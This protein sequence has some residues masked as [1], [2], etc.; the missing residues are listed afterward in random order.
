MDQ[1][2]VVVVGTSHYRFPTEEQA[3]AARDWVAAGNSDTAEFESRFP[4][5]GP[6]VAALGLGRTFAP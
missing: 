1:S 2:S 5:A 3:K 6:A 4:E